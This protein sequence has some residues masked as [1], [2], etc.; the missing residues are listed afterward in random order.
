MSHN[1]SN[2]PGAHDNEQRSVDMFRRAAGQVD[3]AF[4]A[5]V[6]ELILV[7]RHGAAQ[8]TGDCAFMIDIDLAGFG[9]PWDDFMQKGEDLRDEYATQSDSSYYD[10]Q[11][12]F[13]NVLRERAP[14]YSTEFFRQRFE[15][16]AQQ[17]L[18]RLLDLRRQQ[19]YGVMRG[20]SL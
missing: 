1:E 12:G 9:A 18:R 15:A 5:R 17:N 10:G 8:R 4:T 14:F 20:P 7:T 13:L 16:T 19:G 6:T 11:V 3:N 2:V